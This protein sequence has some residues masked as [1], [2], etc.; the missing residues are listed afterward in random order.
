MLP[1]RQMVGNAQKSAVAADGT[2]ARTTTSVVN[3]IQGDKELHITLT[4]GQADVTNIKLFLAAFDTDAA[5]AAGITFAAEGF[6]N[7]AEFRSYFRS[8]ST[9]IAGFR[10]ETTDTDNY[11]ASLTFLEKDP[12]G[13][14]TKVSKRLGQY[15]QNLGGGQYSQTLEVSAADINFVVWAGQQVALSKVKATT[16]VDIYFNVRGW[17]KSQDLLDLQAEII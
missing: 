9:L 7:W 14:E 2:S 5:V 4:A 11:N 3:T 16:T 12:S 15:R 17:N 1:Q 8:V 6:A 10:M 13:K